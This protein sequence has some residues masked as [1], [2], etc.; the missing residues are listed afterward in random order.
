MSHSP[1]PSPQ[2]EG[3]AVHS[4]ERTLRCRRRRGTPGLPTRALTDGCPQE[5][6][7]AR[8]AALEVT[9][10]PQKFR[11]AVPLSRGIPRRSAHTSHLRTSEAPRSPSQG[12]SRTPPGPPPGCTAPR[13]IPS[14]GGPAWLPRRPGRRGDAWAAGTEPPR[15][16]AASRLHRRGREDASGRERRESRDALLPRAP[17]A[18]SSQLRARGCGGW[19]GV[20]RPGEHRGRLG[21]RHRLCPCPGGGG[22]FW[23]RVSRSSQRRG[24]HAVLTVR[25]LRGQ[26]EQ[27]QR[28][29]QGGGGSGRR[30]HGE[31]SGQGPQTRTGEE[32]RRAAGSARGQSAREAVASRGRRG[33]VAPVILCRR[34]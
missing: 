9:W 27:Q 26:Q 16:P 3:L 24:P 15:A 7:A 20:H 25:G 18:R 14:P 29:A 33:A 8:T 22:V 32:R 23:R 31:D 2:Y 19:A 21:C 5:C 30:R 10:R 12:R 11:M 4:G 28:G 1:P 6:G 13:Y 17:H 34:L